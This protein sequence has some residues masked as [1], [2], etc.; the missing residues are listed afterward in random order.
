[1][2]GREAVSDSFN[3]VTQGIGIWYVKNVFD[4]CLYTFVWGMG[5]SVGRMWGVCMDM[6]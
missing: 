4:P 6:L 3:A 2:T 5:F 1:M